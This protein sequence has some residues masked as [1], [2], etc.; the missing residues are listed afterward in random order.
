MSFSPNAHMT[1]TTVDLLI[2]V[3]CYET[4]IFIEKNY[5]NKS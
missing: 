4:M 5:N 1:Y 2:L 3:G